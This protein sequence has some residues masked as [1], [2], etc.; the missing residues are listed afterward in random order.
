V[1]KQIGKRGAWVGFDR[2][3]TLE[4]MVSDEKRVRML[5]K[6]LDAGY[7]SQLLL[8]S[9][10]TGAGT[11][12]RPLCTRTKTVFAPRV[13]QAGVHEGV[14]HTILYHNPRRFLAFVP[15]KA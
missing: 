7:A 14:V 9:D 15:R 11:A 1:I 4:Q 8:S 10:F 2:V 12:E 5:R 6:F 13:I 3:N